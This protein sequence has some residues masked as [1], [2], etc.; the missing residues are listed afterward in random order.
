MIII[1][2]VNGNNNNN[3]NSNSIKDNKA[4]MIRERLRAAHTYY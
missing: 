1:D 2:N 4:I 3:T